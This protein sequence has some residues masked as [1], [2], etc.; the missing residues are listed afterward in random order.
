MSG[1][2]LKRSMSDDG[3]EDTTADEELG[4]GIKRARFESL[5]ESQ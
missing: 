4:G 5:D 2:G 3:E 1:L